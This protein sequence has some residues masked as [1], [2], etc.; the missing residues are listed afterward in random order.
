MTAA[1]TWER[2]RSAVDSPA[3][4]RRV[5]RPDAGARG[6]RRRRPGASTRL[7]LSVSTDTHRPPDGVMLDI[8]VAVSSRPATTVMS[9]GAR[10]EEPQPGVSVPDGAQSTRESPNGR[11]VSGLRL[12]PGAH[13]RAR[14]AGPSGG[15][16][17]DPRKETLRVISCLDLTE[18]LRVLAVGRPDQRPTILHEAREVQVDPTA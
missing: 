12:N 6:Y 7:R 8:G 5:Y 4:A 10:Y 2:P 13:R 16:S 1:I 11:A 3:G 15:A 18:A 17:E 9:I 14:A